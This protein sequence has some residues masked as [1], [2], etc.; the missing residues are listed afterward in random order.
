MSFFQYNS[1]K[2]LHFSAFIG[3]L[4][5]FI[6]PYEY[7]LYIYLIYSLFW[8]SFLKTLKNKLILMDRI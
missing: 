5:N 1:E 3:T 4:E 8:C 2:V 7:H 6:F